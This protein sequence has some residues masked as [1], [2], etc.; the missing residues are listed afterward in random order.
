MLELV[1]DP[2][3]DLDSADLDR[4]TLAVA[5]LKRLVNDPVA[6]LERAGALLEGRA[7]PIL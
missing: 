2:P 1:P 7:L 5:R 4:L 3:A 6:L